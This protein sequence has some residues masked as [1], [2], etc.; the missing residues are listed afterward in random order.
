MTSLV[1]APSRGAR[2]VRD[3]LA[4]YLTAAF[5]PM[6]ELVLDSWDIPAEEQGRYVV[7]AAIDNYEAQ[8]LDKWP[9]VAINVGTAR[10]PR[11][12]D[13]EPGGAPRYRWTYACRL[14]LWVRCDG[15]QDTQKLRDDYGAM[16]RALL[17]AK[18]SL[19]V[20]AGTWPATQQ[21]KTADF[22]VDPETMSEDYSDATPAKGDRWLAAAGCSFDLIRE[23][24]LWSAPVGTADSTSVTAT[25][26]PTGGA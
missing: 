4:T 22:R 15:Y 8:I 11:Q 20:N 9:Y 7:P 5:P 23:E 21:P 6:I 3:Q 1:T 10:N 24:G 16:M 14:I 12:V 17:M 25:L 2:T 18:P 19:R 26:L 13:H